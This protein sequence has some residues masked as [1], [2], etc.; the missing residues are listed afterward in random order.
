M[1]EELAS[2]LVQTAK[3]GYPH[4]RSQ[5]LSLVQQIVDG[6]GIKA[7]GWWERFVNCHPQLSLW[8]GVPLSLAR[9]MAKYF[10]ILE[11]CLVQNG[12][13]EKAAAIFNCDET[14]LPLNPEVSGDCSCMHKCSRVCSTTVC[15]L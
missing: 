15:D 4:S 2:F 5:L 9:A 13:F 1:P 12:I 11:D 6:K 7:T 8:T 14:G 10:Y 3:N